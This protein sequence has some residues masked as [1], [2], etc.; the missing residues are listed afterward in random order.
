MAL[1]PAEAAGIGPADRCEHVAGIGGVEPR[2]HGVQGLGQRAGLLRGISERCAEEQD[3][4]IGVLP[5]GGE[6]RLDPAAHPLSDA[7]A[8]R[9]ERRGRHVGTGDEIGHDH[10][11]AGGVAVDVAG[12]QR[13]E[14]GEAGGPVEVGHGRRG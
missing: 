13:V 5:D 7:R 3:A 9:G 12:F 8:R 6:G 10:A 4:E 2:Q 11:V 1:G 14:L